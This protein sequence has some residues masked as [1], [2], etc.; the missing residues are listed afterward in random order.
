MLGYIYSGVVLGYGIPKLNIAITKYVENKK[1]TPKT[2]SA[3]NSIATNF[4][5]NQIQNN[6]KT[7]G[8]FYNAM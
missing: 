4:V 8:A 1:Q 6:S 7:F 5:Q 3:T 2:T